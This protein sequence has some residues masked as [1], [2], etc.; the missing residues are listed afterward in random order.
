MGATFTFVPFGGSTSREAICCDGLVEGAG[1]HLSHWEKNRT[2]RELKA[3]TSTQMALDFA[4]KNG[5]ELDGR[6]VVNNHFDTDGVLSVLALVRPELAARHRALLVSAAEAGDFDEWPD[7]ERGLML[8]AAVRALGAR[9]G[10]DR[11]AYAAVLPVLGEL[12]SRIG[13]RADLWGD[14]LRALHDAAKRAERG[15]VRVEH[16]GAIAVLVH[17]EGEPEAPGPLLSRMAGCACTRWLLAFDRG[18]GTFSYRYERP[19]YA[20]ADTIERPAIPAPSRNAIARDLGE[21]WSSK[22]ELGMTG[23]LRTTRPIARGPDAIVA[24]LQRNDPGA[25]TVVSALAR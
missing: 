19:R 16:A 11:D 1:L 22:G 2:P 24:A 15:S 10:G 4:E 21:G 6:L 18:D 25:L 9:A 7:D 13:D 20:W 5:S 8:D 14:E 17:R 3:D 23:L 12:L